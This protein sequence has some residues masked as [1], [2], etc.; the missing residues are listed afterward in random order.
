[1]AALVIAR[2]NLLRTL[3]DKTGLFFVFLFPLILIIALGSVFGGF[4]VSRLGVVAADSGALGADL[5]RLIEEGELAVETTTY[6]SIEELR[7]AVEG[8]DVG[9]GVFIP[10]GYDEELRTGQSPALTVVA[11]PDD[12]LSVGRQAIDAAV[13]EQAAQVNA[14]RLAGDFADAEFDTALEQARTVQAALPGIAVRL[15]T[16]GTSVFPTDVGPFAFG[17]QSQT[18]LFMFLTSMTAATQLILTRQLGVSRRMLSTRTPV[19]S[20]LGG[21]LLGRFSIAMMQGIFIVAASALLFGVAWGNLVAASLIIVAFALIGTGVAM[22]VGVF[23]NNVDQA[24]AI[25]VVAGLVLGAL[26]GA[27]VPAELFGEPLATI[28]R[29]TPHAWAIDALRDVAFRGAGVGDILVQ[30]AVLAAMAIV[31]VVIGV[32]GMR[33]SLIRG[34]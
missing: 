1:M 10:A 19:S 16:V 29:I 34:G 17:A 28:S 26:G 4:S 12:R 15:T 11:R 9:M 25:G 14:A 6:A 18:I 23:A 5:V 31:L 3:R 21:E 33:R 30:L 32:W 22:I 20:I 8:G 13:A 7:A 27:M 24:A 2:V